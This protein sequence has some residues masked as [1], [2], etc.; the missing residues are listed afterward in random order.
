MADRA[1]QRL[2]AV[3]G[4]TGFIGQALVAALAARG[5]P[6]R[7][8]VQRAGALAPTASIEVSELGAIGP[9]TRWDRALA[10]VAA[11]VHLAGVAHRHA[12]EGEHARVTVGGASSLA[13]AAREAGVRRIVF[14]SSVKAAAERTLGEPLRETAAARPE[15]EYGKAKLEAEAIFAAAK[16]LSA[17]SLR[18]PLVHAPDARANFAALLRW[19][20][21]PVPLP[22]TN[23]RS[24]IARKSLVEAIIAV[25]DSPEGP[26]GVYY[27]AD[28]PALSTA[29]IVA[30]LRRGL[31]DMRP[32]AA[33]P[34]WLCAAALGAPG[35]GKALAPLFESL[36]VDDS[37]F[38]GLF[39]YGPRQDVASAAALQETAGSWLAAQ[40]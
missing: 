36:A 30:A 26:A 24:L 28:Q 19:A 8:L 1:K 29:A 6:V 27:V 31:G 33:A 10:G 14:L 21:A 2:T 7:A 18:A 38:R 11:V 20:R 4:A 35:L 13:A 16:D 12:K 17:I 32:V 25:L 34:P 39:G 15:T 22:A 37:A 40:P 3:T 9:E 23:Q 5:R